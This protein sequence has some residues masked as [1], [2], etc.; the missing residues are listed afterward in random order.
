VS[1]IVTGKFHVSL[2]P[3][4]LSD[5]IESAADTV[6]PAARARDI[7]LELAIDPAAGP[8]S[9]DASRLRQ[10]IGNLLSNAMKVAPAR[11][12][13]QVR[14]GLGERELRTSTGG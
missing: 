7:R 4:R 11:G 13:V 14:G 9:G 1:R 5:V 2:G 3:V 12:R 10:G 6:R 8:V